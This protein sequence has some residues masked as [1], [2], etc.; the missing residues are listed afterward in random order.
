MD[1]SDIDLGDLTFDVSGVPFPEPDIGALLGALAGQVFIPP[2]VIEDIMGV[3]MLDFLTYA[4]SNLP[5]PPLLSPDGWL[6][7]LSEYLAR[8]E[9]TELIMAELGDA[10]ASTDLEEQIGAALQ[11]VLAASM[12]A[13]MEQLMGV[14][15]MQM[16]AAMS[17]AIQSVMQTAMTSVMQS[18]STQIEIAMQVAMQSLSAQIGKAIQAP[19]AE[20]SKTMESAMRGVTDQI[21]DAI[22]EAFEEMADDMQ[23]SMDGFD[24]DALADA[25][26]IELGED[27]IF[28]LMMSIMNPVDKTFEQNLTML[29]YADP[30]IPTQIL[31][32]PRSF[33]AKQA[34]LDILE[35][36]NT[37][38]E[39][40]DQPD[41][42]VHFTDIVGIMM[43][44]VT[45]IIDMVSYALVAFVSV[46][47]IVSSI[48]I[49]VI[50]FISV[51]ERKKEIG[52]LRA[53]GASK[54]NIRLV[55][56]AETLI[57][58]FVAG[59][60]GVFAT[61]GIIIVANIVL[62]NQLGI[63][64]LV[65]MPPVVPL[66]LVLISMFLTYI[67][68]LLPASAAASKPPVDA[69]RSE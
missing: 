59:V 19:M 67:A 28:E 55:F 1:F 13:Y 46:A 3:I 24:A 61:F 10:L 37:R 57:I 2:V 23:S 47:L 16:Q 33:E 45:D 21:Q 68:G 63:E 18:I 36:Y 22:K 20:L 64:Q 29:G 48:M 27:E 43:S 66:I 17:N 5:F 11:E 49:G 7:L 44:T 38:M 42:V 50:T 53:V 6:E 60:I 34:V 69:L 26:N 32:Y 56:N 8:E 41:K 39:E 12:M 54:G 4:Y 14:I 62:Y 25:F 15:Q 51:L 52:I 58:G 9:T 30:G 65:L 40:T 35:R 31:I